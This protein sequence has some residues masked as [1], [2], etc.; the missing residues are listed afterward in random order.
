V[1]AGSQINLSQLP[2]DGSGFDAVGIVDGDLLDL[3]GL[4]VEDVERNRW[5]E[6]RGNMANELEKA[7]VAI[8]GS[9]EENIQKLRAEARAIRQRL[10]G[11]G[12]RRD[13]AASV[14]SGDG[15]QRQSAAASTG[16]VE[17]QAADAAASA[18]LA[19]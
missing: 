12:A 3:S 4:E 15:T 5:L 13:D 17:T 2:A 10:A 6:L 18:K 11:K 19:G 9:S 14:S 8:I 7:I 1:P 16:A